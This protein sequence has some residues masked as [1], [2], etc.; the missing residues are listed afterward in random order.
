MPIL[1]P[2][3]LYRDDAFYSGLAVDYDEETGRINR[4]VHR[5]EV[6]ADE[7]TPLPGRALM[8]GFINC[9]SHSFQRL[10]RGRP[11]IAERY[12]IAGVAR[13]TNLLGIVTLPW[14]A[15]WRGW[16]RTAGAALVVILPA[17]IW[18]DYLWSIYRAGSAAAGV[19]HITPPFLA[20]LKKWSASV[21]AVGQP[22]LFT[23]AGPTLLVVTA[24][25]VQATY[26]A[27]RRA[28]REPWWRLATAYAILMVVVD[29]V[30]WSG[31]PGAITRVILP[32]TFGFNVLLAAEGRGFWP[33]FVPGN[34]HLVSGVSG[35]SGV[36]WSSL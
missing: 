12:G 4:V 3:L 7:V 18:Q 9:H 19:D 28:W 20:W 34:L 5:L 26:L 30:V 17:L 35:L 14:P 13:E 11:R 22:G 21:Q 36:W 6:D 2:D 16:L 10:I 8:P 24:L 27:W 29:Y 23:H 15:G 32:M 25:S 33:W 1:L 31:Y